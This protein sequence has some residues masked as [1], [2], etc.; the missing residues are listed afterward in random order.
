M[1]EDWINLKTF[2]DHAQWNK[3][4]SDINKNIKKSF[5]SQRPRD[6]SLLKFFLTSSVV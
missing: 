4:Y 5:Q 6:N 1:L 2:E 3:L